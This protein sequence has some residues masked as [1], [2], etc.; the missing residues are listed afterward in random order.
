[1]TEITRDLIA[2]AILIVLNN[3]LAMTEAAFLASR[4]ARLQQMVNENKKGAQKALALA[5]E[6]NKFLSVIQ[7]GIT[8]IDVM[9]GAIGGAT[10]AEFV[11]LKLSAI[12][13]LAAYAN[14]LGLGL[15]VL[16]ITYFS[17]VLGELVPKRLGILNPEG[18]I[19][20]TSG[21]MY[22]MARALAPVVRLLSVSTEGILHLFGVRNSDAP[23]ITEEELHVLINEGTQ[24]G[25]FNSAEQEMVSGVFRLGDR[26]VY[27]LMTPRTEIVWIDIEDP[28]EET[29]RLIAENPFSRYPLC[30]GDLDNV[31]GVVKA[32]DILTHVLHHST[33]DLMRVLQPAIFVPETTFAAQALEIFKEHQTEMLIVIDEYGGVQ[34]MVTVQ[35]IVEEVVGEIDHESPQALQRPDGSWLLDGMMPIDD[36]KAL[37]NLK[38]LP[39]EEAFETLAGFIMTLLG[40]IP[41]TGDRAMWENITLEVVDMDGRRVDKVLVSTLQKKKAES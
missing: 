15:V 29:L 14:A 36:F 41:Q 31:L 20:A 34:G 13:Q 27:S 32:R 23:P 1:M 30:R 6:P 39:R 37:F 38:S 24:A 17:I 16:T 35:D 9:T 28:P 18:I 40:R 10:L 3:L 25:I 7:I 2:I 26:R 8:L 5:E 21:L 33:L 19:T 12:P 22:G 4:R 11:A